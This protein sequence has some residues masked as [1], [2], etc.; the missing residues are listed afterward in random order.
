M[1][2]RFPNPFENK[3]CLPYYIWYPIHYGYLAIFLSIAGALKYF[4]NCESPT[5]TYL[6][7]QYQQ[8]VFEAISASTH[9]LPEVICK[10]ISSYLVVGEDPDIAQKV[11]HKLKWRR[12]WLYFRPFIKKWVYMT[13]TFISL[14][15][16]VVA[17]VM[18]FFE[19]HSWANEQTKSFLKYEGFFVTLTYLPG[20]ILYKNP[21]VTTV[22]YVQPRP[23]KQTNK[24]FLV[25]WP[26]EMHFVGNNVG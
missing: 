3:I 15:L 24:R 20:N 7:E 25:Y 5:F 8:D 11:Y 26:I 6:N 2:F 23:N 9:Q 10:E 16:W 17:L 12:P 21:F 14:I 13:Y 19:Y 1:T 4:C 22:A 18:V